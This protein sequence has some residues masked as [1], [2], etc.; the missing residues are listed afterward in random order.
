MNTFLYFSLL[1]SLALRDW[2]KF[3]QELLESLN[4]AY[5]RLGVSIWILL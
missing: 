2:A 4:E 1:L 5:L 3:L